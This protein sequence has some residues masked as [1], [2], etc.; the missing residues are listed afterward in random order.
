MTEGHKHREVKVRSFDTRLVRLL[1]RPV[2]H[3]LVIFPSGNENHEAMERVDASPYPYGPC[4]RTDPKHPTCWVLTP[5]GI[6]HRWTGLT[7]RTPDDQ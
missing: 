1:R 5:L 3:V 2:L 4:P 6:L 7:L